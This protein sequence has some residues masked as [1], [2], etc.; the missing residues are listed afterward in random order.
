M[1]LANHTC[2]SEIFRKAIRQYDS[3]VSKN[4]YL[5]QFRGEHAL[6]EDDLEEF[7]NC[8]EVS[9]AARNVVLLLLP[10]K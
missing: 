7:S 2:M 3:L 9:R 4:A 5:H 6:F 10:K 8:R 1:M